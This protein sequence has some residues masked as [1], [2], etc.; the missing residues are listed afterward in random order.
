M[1]DVVLAPVGELL[2]AEVEQFLASQ[3]APVSVPAVWSGVVEREHVEQVRV[4]PAVAIVQVLSDAIGLVAREGW[5][6]GR[7]RDGEGFCLV[8]ALEAAAGEAGFVVMQTA[9][10]CIELTLMAATG[11]PE[12]A[13]RWNDDLRRTKAE[14]LGLLAASVTVAQKL[15]AR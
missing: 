10:F 8:G 3:A 7:Y 2:A 12:G 9:K 11:R 5:T 14:V 6:Q 4:V 1:G 15:G 13:V